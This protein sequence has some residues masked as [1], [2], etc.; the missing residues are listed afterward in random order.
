MLFVV[1]QGCG[2]CGEDDSPGPAV[3]PGDGDSSVDE[4]PDDPDSGDSPIDVPDA[5]AL[6]PGDPPEELAGEQCAADTNKIY[7]LVTTSANAQPPSLAQ[8]AGHFGMTYVTTTDAACAT[9]VSFAEMFG[10]PGAHEPSPMTAYD[11]CTL[12]EQAAIARGDD[13]WLIAVVDNRQEARDLWVHAFDSDSGDTNGQHRITQNMAGE[14]A[15]ELLR[16]TNDRVLIVWS[17]SAFDN[18][19]TSLFGQFLSG[20]G[21]PMDEPVEI[22]AP[23]AGA[24]SSMSM[25]LL[26]E[27]YVGLA[28]IH[29]DGAGGLSAVLDVLNQETAERDR[30]PWV[31][32]TEPGVNG[33]ID[34][35]SDSM[36]AGVA[37]TI[38]QGT[39]RQ[40]WFQGLGLD[41][42]A[43][44]VLGG[45][46]AGGPS[47]PSRIVENPQLAI[48]VSMA[49]M[50][51]GFAI[52]YRALP[53][54]GV[55]VPQIRAHFLDRDGRIVGDSAVALAELAGGQTAIEMS[56]DGRIALSWMDT[57]EDGNSTLRALMVPCG[58]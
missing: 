21:E 11:D 37:Y 30:D 53:S 40:V 7:E 19:G 10:V 54:V 5:E 43:S 26:G 36:A 14:G 20:S 52:A 24:Y 51:R 2:G 27:S 12:V 23:A 13:A 3:P 45:G 47:A 46:G 58:S 1:L 56:S 49:K 38:V 44:P 42:L 31:L 55:T 57:D 35:A 8:F 34:L 39:S 25:V 15:V 41:G 22:A 18:S 16:I 50:P 28:Y 48:D 32:T 4:E 17:E 33:T 6:Y 29:D 9:S